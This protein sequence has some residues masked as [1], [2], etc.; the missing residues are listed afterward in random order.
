MFCPRPEKECLGA[1]RKPGCAVCPECGREFSL[2][3]EEAPGVPC[4]ICKG[5]RL[6]KSKQLK[7]NP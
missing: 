3:E 5:R 1:C 6:H 2:E 4:C 7:G